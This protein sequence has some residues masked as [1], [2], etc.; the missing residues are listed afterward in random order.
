MASKYDWDF[1]RPLDQ[2][3]AIANMT[4]G[5]Q[6]I[7][8]G[9]QGISGAVT[10]YADAMKQRNTDEI[11]NTLMSAQST[12]DLPNAMN[13][14]QALQ[15]QYGRGYDQSAVRNAIDTR[16]ATLGQR[17]LQ[18]INLQQAQAAQA[19]IPQLNQSAALEAIRQGA[20][21]EQVNALTGLGIDATGQISRYGTNAQGDTR[22]AAEGAERRANRKEEVTFRNQQAK[23]QQSNWQYDADFR[24]DES[25]WRRGGEV[26]AD[27]PATNNLVYSNGNWSTVSTPK[28]S[29][30]DAYGALAGVRGIR[31]NNPGNLGFAGQRGASRE[32]GSGRFAS[33][34]TPEEGIAAMSK[35]L[36]LHF[37]GKSAKAKELGRPLQS[38]TDII[39]AWAPPNENDTKAYI[40]TVAKQ[41]GVSPTARLNMNDSATKTALMQ[42][43][44]KKENG[45][46]PYTNEQYAAGISGATS[47][48]NSGKA[49]DAVNVPQA[50]AAK[51]VGGYNT[52]ITELQNKFNLETTQNQGKTTL[53]SKGQTI[54]SWLASKPVAER[55]GSTLITN[56]SNKVAKLA[57]NNPKLANLP[58]D[59]QL[60]ILDA[61]HAWSLAPGGTITD[62]ELNKH[63]TNLAEGVI[64]NNKAV[65]EQGKKNIFESQYQAF[66]ADLNSSGLSALSRDAFES[67]V[68]PKRA[69][70][71]RITQAIKPAATPTATKPTATPKAAPKVSQLDR[72]LAERAERKKVQADAAIRRLKEKEVKEVKSTAKPTTFRMPSGTTTMSQ[73]QIDELLKKYQVR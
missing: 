50:V 25:D 55:E 71:T 10:G 73:A 22:Y 28:I 45:G 11:L 18:N 14:V 9:L 52:A 23:Q 27:N 34:N 48:S 5:N 30:V 68:A 41:L 8:A 42:A 16:G 60:K 2:T 7:N 40:A 31:N 44:V 36:D 19:A 64:R 61:S 57:R 21:A 37:T 54:D 29:R 39:S 26:A 15:Q 47:S 17:D 70:Y 1:I 66:N 69:N 33:F 62:K 4:S 49:L 72:N 13:A 51:A 65:L 53:G 32:N 3:S 46:N 35:Q 24:A 67:L 56:Y 20:N 59:D 6:Q 12:A 58:V 38:V 43:I 63:I